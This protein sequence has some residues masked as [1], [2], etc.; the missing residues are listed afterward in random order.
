MDICPK[1]GMPVP[2]L[3][4]GT[5]R[6]RDTDSHNRAA[7]SRPMKTSLRKYEFDPISSCV[8]CFVVGDVCVV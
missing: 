5:A 4:R 3:G 6:G 2:P 8:L 7:G 1:L